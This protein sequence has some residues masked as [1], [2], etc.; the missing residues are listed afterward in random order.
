MGFQKKENWIKYFPALVSGLGMTLAFPNSEL[1]L[2][3]F[4][5]LVPLILIVRDATPKESF[6]LGFCAGLFHF[7]TLIYWIIPTVHVYGGLH[8]ILAVSTLAFLCVYLAL[9]PAIFAWGL[10]K[11]G[12]YT[13]YTP[14]FASALWVGLEYIRT[15]AFTGFAWGALGYSQYANLNFIQI[16]DFSGVYGISFLIVL[17]NCTLGMA[18]I[19]WRENTKKPFATMGLTIMLLAGALVYGHLK[20]DR[21]SKD[22]ESVPKT[23]VSV[24]QGNIRQDQKWDK[25]FK[26]TTVEKYVDLS[27]KQMEN[28]PD[29]VIWP[30]TAL[31]FYYGFDRPMSEKVNAFARSAGT[32]ILVGSPAVVPND[33][34]MEYYN[35]AYMI[36]RFSVVTGT[37]DKNH[38]VPFGEYVPLGKYLSFL[39][40]ITAQAGNFSSGDGFY[41]PLEFNK[42]KT[43]VLI[44]FESLFPSISS[45]FVK[46]GA[47]ILTTI[48]NDAWFGH[49]S[50]PKQHFS[51]AVLRAVENRRSMARAANTG[52]SGFIDPAGRILETTPM[53]S[54]TAITRALPVLEKIS[55]YTAYGDIFAMSAM[56]A[57][58]FVF[59]LKGARKFAKKA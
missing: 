51:I 46:N 24:V 31:P 27:A 19:S 44:C 53:F 36:N 41:K 54:D 23:V 52:I 16:A 13:W 9:Y 40:K 14:F 38:L 37:Y 15:Y 6:L 4:F 34:Q 20:M 8:S 28:K 59:V 25:A 32:H 58:C 3:A 7:L 5:A 39:G 49:T 11:T 18:W 33:K 30:E 56:V 48:T 12:N 50:A 35:R 17:V 22:I 55:F 1:W 29:L 43:G 45:A 10:K 42:M 47:G 26:T 2:L 21:I 57:I